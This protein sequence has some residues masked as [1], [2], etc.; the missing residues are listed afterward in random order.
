[1]TEAVQTFFAA[2]SVTDAQERRKM[3]AGILGPGASYA[4]PRT[5]NA[6]SDLD[7]L[8]DYIG[9]FVE[10]APGATAKVVKS[11]TILQSERATIAFEMA[12]GMVQHGQ[13]FVDFDGEKITR[14][15]GFVGTGTPE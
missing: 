1:M 7:A 2:W 3:L 14:M 10:N 15:V 11:D 8:N 4:D 12:N 13:Y 9:M 6:V 5:P